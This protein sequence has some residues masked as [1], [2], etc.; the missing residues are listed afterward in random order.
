MRLVSEWN[1]PF[2]I[3]NFQ[4][5]ISEIFCKWK[6]PL[7][8]HLVTYYVGV[9]ACA[10]S[11]ILANQSAVSREYSA[12]INRA[13]VDFFRGR[14]DVNTPIRNGSCLSFVRSIPGGSAYC[15]IGDRV[16]SVGK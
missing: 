6:T 1:A 13:K 16:S 8:S 5:K 3:G 9:N 14:Y 4:R 11:V 12:Q 2:P 10:A 7:L 15:K